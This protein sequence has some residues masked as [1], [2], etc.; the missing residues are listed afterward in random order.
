M[1]EVV[2]VDEYQPSSASLKIG[3]DPIY[4]GSSESETIRVA[5]PAV[6]VLA[7]ILVGLVAGVGLTVYALTS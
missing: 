4:K 7:L 2:Y 6:P 3:Q 5:V 1:P